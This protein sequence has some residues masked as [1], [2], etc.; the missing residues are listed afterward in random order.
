M[1]GHESLSQ[2]DSNYNHKSNHNHKR[3]SVA[4]RERVRQMHNR[5]TKGNCI[6]QLQYIKQLDSVFAIMLLD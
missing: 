4:D 5:T 3:G 6:R 2:L 1:S